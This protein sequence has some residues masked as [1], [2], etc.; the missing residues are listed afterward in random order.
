MLVNNVHL[1]LGEHYQ[2]KGCIARLMSFG[3]RLLIV[4]LILFDFRNLPAQEVGFW[5][6]TNQAFF[7]PFISELRSADTKIDLGVFKHYPYSSA[8]KHHLFQKKTAFLGMD[9]SL[10]RELPIM[11]YSSSSFKCGFFIPVSFHLLWDIE[12]KSSPVLNTDYRFGTMIKIL[13]ENKDRGSY[14]QWLRFPGIGIRLVPWLHNSSHLGDEYTIFVLTDSSSSKQFRRVNVS[15]EVYDALLFLY[16]NAGDD[17][18]DDGHVQLGVGQTRR[19]G[20]RKLGYYHEKVLGQDTTVY[21]SDAKP[22]TYFLA[23]FYKKNLQFLNF[24]AISSTRVNIYNYHNLE[25]EQRFSHSLIVGYRFTSHQNTSQIPK[26][27]SE[28][29]FRGY[30]G[31]NPNGQFKSQKKFWLITFGLRITG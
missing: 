29:Y 30:R 12:G 3:T 11:G 4:V 17:A 24:L 21:V 1:L 25:S 22:E 2:C 15:Y 10:G 28:I 27:L 8:V 23:D 14:G 19:L 6:F 13:W 20:G 16:F 18:G 7:P 5:Q 9:I 31:A 26:S